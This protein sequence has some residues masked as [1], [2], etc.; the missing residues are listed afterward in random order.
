MNDVPIKVLFIE[1]NTKDVP[2]V[3]S[4]LSE[5]EQSRFQFQ[6]VHVEHLSDAI[7]HFSECESDVVL[8]GLSFPGTQGLEIIKEVN[9]AAPTVPIV[10]LSE[11][12]DEALSLLAVEG[13]AQDYLVKGH[14]DSHLLARSLQYAIERKQTEATLR[15]S[16]ER[17]R[18]QYKEVPIPWFSWKRIGEDF[19]LADYNHAAE[20]FMGER[21]SDFVGRTAREIHRSM[22]EVLENFS[23]CFAEKTTIKWEGPYTL[24]PDGEDKYVSITYVFVPPDV[25]MVHMEDITERKR[26][27]EEIASL[28][29]FPS[30]NPNPVMRIRKDGTIFYA[31][32]ASSPLLRA[33]RVQKGEQ[34]PDNLKTTVAE[35]FTHSRNKNIEVMCGDRIFMVLLA[36]VV[37]ATYVNLYGRDITEHKYAEEELKARI[38]EQ[39][40]IAQL[41]QRALAGTDLPTLLDE[42]V[43][44]VAQVLGV[45]Y[46]A[47]LEL[48]PDGKALLLRKGEGW[49]AGIVGYG[50]VDS[51]STSQ[52]GYTLLSNEPVVVE[53]L[54][55]ETRFSNTLVLREHG[56]VSG[57]SVIIP[58]RERPFG[59]LCAHSVKRRRFSKDD[60]QFLQTI[61][62]LLATFIERRHVEASLRQKS[63]FVQLLGSVAVAANEGS[64]V[65]EVLQTILGQVCSYTGWPIGHV[66]FL[67]GESVEE[68]MPSNLWYLN[69]KKRLEDFREV[70]DATQFSYGDGII[71][72]VLSSVM[73]I[74]ISDV[75]QDPSFMRIKQAKELGIRAGFAFPVLMGTR[76]AAVLEFFSTE[77]I[78]P[79]E[80]LLEV[81]AHIGTQLG[82]VVERKR[83]EKTIEF[84]A[85]HDALTG[86]PNRLL[87]KDRLA[88]ALARAN[89][90]RQPLA[91][92]FLDLDRFKVINDTLGHSVGDMLLQSVSIRLLSC[93]REG[94][95][96]ARMGGDEFTLV[97]P[98]ISSIDQVDR[99]IERIFDALKPAFLLDGHKLHITASIGIAIYPE[100]GTDAQTLSSH[101]DTALYIA[102][103]H[104]RNTF[105]YYSPS[106]DARALDR[107]AL[108][109]NL[110]TALECEEFLLHYQPLVDLHTGKII[111]MEALVRW[112]RP[113]TGLVSPADFIPIAEET[114]L[115]VPLGEWVLRK[116]CGQN[117]VWK[118]AGYSLN[119]AVN[120]S[121]R[122]F[123]HENLQKLVGRILEETGLD[124]GSLELELTES[125]LMQREGAIMTMLKDLNAMGVALSIDDFGTGYSSLSYLKRF[126]IKKLKIDQSFVQDLLKDQDS[127]AIVTAI[128]TL[129]HSLKVRVIA[130]AVEEQEQLSVL[131]SLGCDEIQGY[132]F[133]PPLPVDAATNLLADD[134]H[135]SF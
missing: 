59:V 103:E 39:A 3:R 73:P 76:I 8:L 120:L 128:I 13:G 93:I 49:K 24:R 129:G 43:S 90:S 44:I 92:M 106:M 74:W 19:I 27:E 56:V 117:V 102:K 127:S 4:M 66:Y 105:R 85:Y 15:Q 6:M 70:T 12:K 9:T 47:V 123:Q 94:D 135:L 125:I 87:S 41:G 89:R 34:L 101:A 18:T 32:E 82:R 71:G 104:G 48:L 114:G 2:L 1:N 95:T 55:K 14:V 69:D 23:R 91:V 17:F 111:G 50:T 99:I 7:K 110:R 28:A 118:K 16:A 63:A 53:D 100:S 81:M 60:V 80:P 79:N 126:P 22:P 83:A 38:H 130:E 64:S 62:T 131:R 77:V 109:N 86:L 58:G 42:V 133:S 21:V 31:N 119:I 112:H 25:V 65:Q 108:E 67:E 68:T 30:E 88:M 11:L 37:D 78:E 52:A 116:A 10:V 124:P 57:V 84:Q 113:E 26:A 72:K 45:Q 61:A 46:S 35:V 115:I 107:L 134:K 5:A 97:L 96:V 29:K 33:W 75:T 36:Y 51:D 98:E 132:L 54:E 122:Q 40:V 20:R 121:A